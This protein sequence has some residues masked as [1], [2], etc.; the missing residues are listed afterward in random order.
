[1]VAVSNQRREEVIL[2]AELYFVAVNCF[3]LSAHIFHRFQQ[4]VEIHRRWWDLIV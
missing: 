3:A 1:M 2:E 4:S